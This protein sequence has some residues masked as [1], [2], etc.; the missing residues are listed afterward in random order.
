[1]GVMAQLK[2]DISSFD[3]TDLMIAVVLAVVG[4]VYMIFGSPIANVLFHGM[5]PIGDG[6]NVVIL[7]P[8]LIMRAFGGAM[9]KNG[10]TAF[11]CI[12][13]VAILRLLTGDPFGFILIQSGLV[14]GIFLWFTMAAF[15]YKFDYKHWILYGIVFA[16]AIENVWVAYWEVW[17]V[18]GSWW[19]GWGVYNMWN[20]LK[21]II[22]GVVCMRLY[23][24]MS[25][26][27]SLRSLMKVQ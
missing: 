20:L 17:P 11:V 18:A 24:T 16:V 2:T 4:R 5:G 23:A 13:L 26:Y 22:I 8:F 12:M 25:R 21:G 10:L 1:M 7:S 15:E 27:R 6:L 3:A 19:L 9:R 14:G